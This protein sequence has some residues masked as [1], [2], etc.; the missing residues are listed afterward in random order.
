[1]THDVLERGQ[2]GAHLEEALE[3]ADVLDDGDRRIAVAGEVLDLLGRRRVVD[4]DRRRAEQ[5]HG[6]VGDVELGPVAHHQHDAVAPPDPELAGARPRPGT[7][8]RRTRRMSALRQPSPSLARAAPP[9]PAG[10]GPSAGTDSGPSGPGSS[11]RAS[12]SSP[13][14]P[15]PPLVAFTICS[16]WLRT[17]S[18]PLS[19]DRSTGALENLGKLVDT[20]K[21]PVPGRSLGR[22]PSA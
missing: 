2:L 7:R 19:T 4:R 9:R 17:L 1:M 13:A 12:R 21:R 16:A 8:L 10:P 11:R 5:Q 6:H 22:P 14:P 18:P 3:E 15:G 20:G